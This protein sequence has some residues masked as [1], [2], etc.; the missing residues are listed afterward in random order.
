[1]IP[2][3]KTFITGNELNCIDKV[4]KSGKVSGNGEFTSMCEDF[5][6]TRY[7]FKKCFLTTSC[8]DAL[9]MSSL[10][11]DINKDDE[12][13]MPSFTFVST[14]NA[15]ILRG[16][17]IVFADCKNDIPNIDPEE[18]KKLVTNKT[19]AIVLIHYAGISCDMDEIT[20]LT[21]SLNL[22]LIEDAALGLDSSYKGIP[23]GRFGDV[24]TFSFHDTKNIVSGEGGMLA[25]NNENLIE[26]AEIIREKGTNRS[27]Y[28]RHLSNKYEWMDIGS[29]YL[30]SELIAAFL[31][32]QL[33]NLGKIQGKRKYIFNRYFQLLKPLADK[34]FIKLPVVPDFAGINGHIFYFLCRSF[35]ERN[36][37]LDY[38]DK[39]NITAAFHYLPLHNSRFFKEMHDGRVLGNAIRFS[40]CLLRL[41]AFYEIKD[42]EISYICESIFNFYKSN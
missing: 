39:K 9:E 12:V 27:A 8:T 38:L 6:E 5:L 29:S 13:I 23:L 7:G 37:L 35:A 18:I 10:L 41:P 28:L 14:A 3:N 36:K 24:S 1:M 4:I 31:Y 22:K 2:F 15:F 40:E 20:E 42:E 17:K 16:A 25:V 30:P 21:S 33:E 32:S 26:R 11:L 34:G 19:K